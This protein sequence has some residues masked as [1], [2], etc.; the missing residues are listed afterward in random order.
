MNV[1]IMEADREIGHSDPDYA[2]DL[3]QDGKKQKIALQD[4]TGVQTSQMSMYIT[5]VKRTCSKFVRTEA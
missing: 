5:A 4:F 2:E 1:C 3:L